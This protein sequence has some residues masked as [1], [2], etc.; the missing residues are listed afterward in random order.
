MRSLPVTAINRIELK[1][2]T[3]IQKLSSLLFPVPVRCTIH[4]QNLLNLVTTNDITY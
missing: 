4:S 3:L 2:R 1:K